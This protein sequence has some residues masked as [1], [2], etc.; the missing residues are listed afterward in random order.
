[1]ILNQLIKKQILKP[2]TKKMETKHTPGPLKAKGLHIYKDG[3]SGPIGQSFIINHK[4]DKR[5]QSIPDEEGEANAILWAAS[6]DLLST[7]Q[8]IVNRFKR[9]E[10]LYSN[11]KLDIEFAESVILKAL[12]KQ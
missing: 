10:P 12:G 2:K 6:P 3:K 1:M 5:G 7:L 4:L 9:V 8:R 11:D